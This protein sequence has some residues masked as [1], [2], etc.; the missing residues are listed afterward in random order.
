MRKILLLTALGVFAVAGVAYAVVSVTNVYVVHAVVTPLNSG[1]PAH[2]NPSKVRVG[3]RVTAVPAGQRPVNVS[4]F[5]ISLEGVHEHTTFFPGCGTSM[6]T[7]RGPSG[8]PAGSLVGGGF[9]IVQLGPTGQSS[10]NYNVTCREEVSI[11][12]GG[13][14][15]MSLYVYK[16][17]QRPGQPVPCPVPSGGHVA[18]NVN[19]VNSVNGVTENFTLPF[20][21]LHPARGA[22]GAVIHAALGIPADSTVITRHHN[23][24]TIHQL[25]GLFATVA[26]THN[27]QRQVAITFTREDGVVSTR[28]TLVP[29]NP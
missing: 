26:C 29:C 8:C 18:I 25:V 6:L 2:P 20:E 1:T 7:N 23:H 19:L 9:M 27:H 15:N 24:V 5:S 22:D 17:N 16:G 13:N 11:Y 21:L 10:T 14:H 4:R 28:T 3:W 12:N